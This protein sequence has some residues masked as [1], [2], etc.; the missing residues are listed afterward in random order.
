MDNLSIFNKNRKPEFYY[1]DLTVTQVDLVGKPATGDTFLSVRS[2]DGTIEN[3]PVVKSSLNGIIREKENLDK[4]ESKLTIDEIGEDKMAKSL[5]EVV[6]KLV[7]ASQNIEETTSKFA[8]VI[9]LKQ[10]EKTETKSE[11]TATPDEGDEAEVTEDK[12]GSTPDTKGSEDTEKQETAEQDVSAESTQDTA[13]TEDAP[14]PAAE[15]APAADTETADTGSDATVAMRSALETLVKNF[16]KLSEN[17]NKVNDRLNNVERSVTV[18][19]TAPVDSNH[20]K[21]ERETQSVFSGV[22]RK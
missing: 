17:L 6:E 20:Q 2:E 15:D 14:A 7:R 18:P 11:D 12:T 9:N 10:P 8:D 19:N 4:T 13:T 5:E 22:I 3:V 21:V 1:E 16:D